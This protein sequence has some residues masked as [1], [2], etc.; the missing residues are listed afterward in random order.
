MC[1]AKRA[2]V[3]CCVECTFRTALP[4]ATQLMAGPALGYSFWQV[5]PRARR[6]LACLHMGPEALLG[7]GVTADGTQVAFFSAT[8]WVRRYIIIELGLRLVE[9]VTSYKM[10]LIARRSQYSTITLRTCYCTNAGEEAMDVQS[11]SSQSIKDHREPPSTCLFFSARSKL[12]ES[13]RRCTY[14][15]RD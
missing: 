2:H 13:R 8:G 1:T 4:L 12:G 10:N 5:R 15:N 11:C 7:V 3:R 14:C 9:E 6:W